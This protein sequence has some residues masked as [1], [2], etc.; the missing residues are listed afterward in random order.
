MS[1][2][3]IGFAGHCASGGLVGFLASQA[4]G[5]FSLG[6]WLSLFAVVVTNLMIG[7]GE[8]SPQ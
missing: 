5:A 3:L 4:F 2:S 7:Y 6:Y 1:R 8:R